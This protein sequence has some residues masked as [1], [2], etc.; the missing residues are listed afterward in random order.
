LL[1][2]WQECR[3]ECG[4]GRQLGVEGKCEPCPRGT[5]RTMGVQAACQGCPTGRTTHRPGAATVEECTLPVCQPGTFLNG[6]QNTCIPCK[7]GTYQ[8]DPQQTTC[9]ACPPN[10]STKGAAAVCHISLFGKTKLMNRSGPNFPSLGSLFP[11][12]APSGY[13]SFL[14]PGS[15]SS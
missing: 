1:H 11:L 2:L 8:P 7:K 13:L 3:D 15:W 14:S 6:T 4:S 9:I 5:Y 10:T 12:F